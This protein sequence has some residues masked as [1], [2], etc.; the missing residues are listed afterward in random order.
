MLLFLLKA[1]LFLIRRYSSSYIVSFNKMA[2]FVE[3]PVRKLKHLDMT[4]S[5][6]DFYIDKYLS[7]HSTDGHSSAH[8]ARETEQLRTGEVAGVDFEN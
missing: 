4:D 3:L 1:F 7:N 2:D 6:R 5:Q 8:S